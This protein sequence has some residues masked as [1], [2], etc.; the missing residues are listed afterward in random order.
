M[1]DFEDVTP[2][3]REAEEQS[4]ENTVEEVKEEVIS[5]AEETVVEEKPAEEKTAEE[6]TAEET[7]PESSEDHV[8]K[9]EIPQPSIREYHYEEQVKK[10]PKKKK[11]WAKFVVGCLLIGIAGGGSIGAGYSFVDHLMTGRNAVSGTP[12]GVQKASSGEIYSAAEIVK[13]VKPSVVSVS[14]KVSGMTNYWGAFSIPYESEGAGS[15]VIF[16]SDDSRVA[17][18]TNNHVIEN[19]NTIYVTF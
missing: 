15:G 1:L 10:A 5:E 11:G 6:K 19:A 7:T 8:E 18:A 12:T 9:E 14:T 2:R 4:S 13:A 16:Y 17:I 3:K